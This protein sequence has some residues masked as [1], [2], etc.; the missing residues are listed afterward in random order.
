MLRKPA[1]HKKTQVRID[2]IPMNI[3][4][5]R[6]KNFK[7]FTDLEINLSS[8]QAPP[9]LVLLTGANGSGKSSVFDAFE[10]ISAPHKQG[11]RD[12]YVDYF[13]KSSGTESSVS[14]TLGG[15]VALTRSKE[16]R[17]ATTPRD[18]NCRSAF[19]GRSSFRTVPELRP[20]GRPPA[21]VASDSD[22][23]QRFIE[24]DIRFDTDISEVTEKILREV[25]GE[26]FNSETMR[27]RFVDPINDSLARIFGNGSSTTLR[28]IRMI[29]ALEQKPPDVRF[30]KGHSDIHYDLLSSGEKE[31]FNIVLNL[32]VRR[33]HFP[34]AIYFID[35]LDVHLHTR[36]Q[37]ALLKEIVENWIP[38]NSQLWTASHSLGFIDYA[39]TSADSAIVDFDEFDFDQSLVLRPSPK[40]EQIFDIAVPRDS[41]LKVFPNKNLV[42]CEGRNA[43]LYNAI[44]LP[45]SLFV[46]ARDKNAITIQ[47]RA[48]PDFFGLMDRDF[49]GTEEIREIRRKHSNLFVLGY[50]SIENY[51]YHPMNIAEISPNGFDE[52]AYR[53][54]VQR[55]MNVVRDRMLVN[56]ARNC[57]SYEIIKEFSR[58]LK[59]KAI[60]EITRATGSTEFEEF[61]PFLDM[62]TN[63]PGDYLAGFNLQPRDLASTGWMRDSIGKIIGAE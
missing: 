42:L 48:L 57:N 40:S 29:P 25:W 51:L 17:T 39:S 13:E 62:K 38:E 54:A 4:K 18:W 47:A 28:L 5:L 26:D 58:E 20:R 34:N 36:L 55:N 60:E 52:S 24:H 7:R 41:A 30:E 21:N 59:D 32:F 33:E 15:G 61:Y 35:E 43:P 63:R 50:Y 16:I 11:M 9:K 19:Y 10:Y 3:E 49:L 56:L 8:C 22:R 23:P 53:E 31:V 37:F 12:H 2:G 6:V 1:R 14:I 27:A 45:D 46:A 44:D